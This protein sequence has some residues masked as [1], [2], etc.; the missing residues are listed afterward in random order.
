MIVTN[1]TLKRSLRMLF[2]KE[3]RK[4]R[5]PELKR[6]YPIIKSI[7]FLRQSVKNMVPFALHKRTKKLLDYLFNG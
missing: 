6:N 2:R 3:Q 4:P 1:D 7:A 5:I